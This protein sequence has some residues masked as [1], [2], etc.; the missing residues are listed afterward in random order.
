[1]GIFD[2][3][4]AASQQAGIFAFYLP[5]LITFALMYGLLA[6][7]GLLGQASRMTHGLNALI[8]FSIAICFELP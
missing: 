4:I 2:Q 6:R 5:F 3:L 7:I 1:M 8:A